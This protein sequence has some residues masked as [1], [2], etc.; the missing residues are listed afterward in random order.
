MSSNSLERTIDKVLSQTESELISQIDSGFQE[1]LAKLDSSRTKLKSEY[2]AIIESAKKEAEN[3]KRQIVGSSRLTARNK[4]LVLIESAINEIFRKVKE[5]L[6]LKSNDK[7]YKDLLRKMI[8]ESIS[9]LDSPEIVIECNKNDLDVVKKIVQDLSADKKVK[10]ALSKKPIDIVGGI[11][12]V[13]ADG[14][15]TLDNSLDSKIERLKPLI[16]KD[17]VQLLRGE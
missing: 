3:L 8:E 9:R 15:M 2:E 16:R 6:Q 17:I 14:T 12:A 4:E 7:L 11:R 13:S 1:A 5:K 10:L